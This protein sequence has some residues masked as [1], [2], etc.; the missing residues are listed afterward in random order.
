MRSSIPNIRFTKQPSNVTKSDDV[1]ELVCA[2]ES[3]GDVTPGAAA[4]VAGCGGGGRKGLRAVRRA[5]SEFVEQFQREPDG[6][7]GNWVNVTVITSAS[8]SGAPLGDHV[9]VSEELTPQG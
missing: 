6:C 4:A 8:P 7:R 9:I 1:I 2:G 5:R 3:D